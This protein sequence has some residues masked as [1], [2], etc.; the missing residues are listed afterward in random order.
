MSQLF[1]LDY[2]VAIAKASVSTESMGTN[3]REVPDGHYPGSFI[4]V[5]R[6]KGISRSILWVLMS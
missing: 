1:R 6:K 5:T 4:P 2:M 3:L